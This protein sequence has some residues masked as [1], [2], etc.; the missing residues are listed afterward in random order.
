MV[1]APAAAAAEAA[2]YLASAAA[3]CPCMRPKEA[4]TKLSVLRPPP[5]TLL[6]AERL[7]QPRLLQLPVRIRPRGGA[8]PSAGGRGARLGAYWKGPP[9]EPAPSKVPAEGEE[10]RPCPLAPAVAAAEGADARPLT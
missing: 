9:E 1:E 7:G 6:A 8:M 5:P 2:R 10:T 4:A 3:M